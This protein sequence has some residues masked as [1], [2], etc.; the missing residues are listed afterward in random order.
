MVVANYYCS[1]RGGR[2]ESQL[3]VA[4]AKELRTTFAE[5]GTPVNFVMDIKDYGDDAGTACS[6]GW[7][8]TY[9]SYAGEGQPYVVA[10][11]NYKLRDMLFPNGYAHP[12][13]AVLDAKGTVVAK[14]VGYVH[15]INVHSWLLL[16]WVTSMT[17]L[18]CTAP[19]LYGARRT[20]SLSSRSNSK[21]A[22]SF[23]LTC[24]CTFR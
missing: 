13:Y 9:S 2:R 12:S 6:S 20:L 5:A 15:H 21:A 18:G 3:F 24:S 11:S 10:D 4:A 16:F 22:T 7:Q 17:L 1:C 8:S 23:M 19:P 14:F